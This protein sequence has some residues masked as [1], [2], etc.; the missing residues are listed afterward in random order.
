MFKKVILSEYLYI[1]KSEINV[2][3][4]K[5][6]YTITGKYKNSP[7]ISYY[8]ETPDYIGIPRHALRLSKEMAETIIDNRTIGSKVDF[9]FKGNLW[10]YQTIITLQVLDEYNTMMCEFIYSNAFITKLSRMDFNYQTE[11][12]ISGDFTFAFGQMDIKL[13]N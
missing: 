7:T 8:K 2:S 1:P 5:Q 10:D 6:R 4:Y 9:K 13:A 3:D 12:E 11:D